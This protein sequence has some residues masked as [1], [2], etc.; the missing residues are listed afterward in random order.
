[1]EK[2]RRPRKIN[3]ENALCVGY[4]SVKIIAL[5]KKICHKK[6]LKMFVALAWE[7]ES[8]ILNTI[9]WIYI[10]VQVFR[11]PYCSW[12]YWMLKYTFVCSGICIQNTDFQIVFSNRKTENKKEKFNLADGVSDSICMGFLW[13]SLR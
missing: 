6:M 7:H 9:F 8:T 3:R 2:N 10:Y 5:S 12:D 1:M 11:V 13:F 4:S